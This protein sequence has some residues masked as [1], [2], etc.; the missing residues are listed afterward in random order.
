MATDSIAQENSDR[1]SVRLAL[2]VSVSFLIAQAFAW[3][4]AFSTPV[5]VALL[6]QAPKLH[7]LYPGM[8]LA[9]FRRAL[10]ARVARD[11]APRLPITRIIGDW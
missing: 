3:P 2:G 8:C 9:I 5:F 1:R 10:I 6:L 11:F 4:L 7:G